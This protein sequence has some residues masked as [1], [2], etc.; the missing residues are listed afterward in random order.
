MLR[1]LKNSLLI[2]NIYYQ[3]IEKVFGGLVPTQSVGTR[4]CVK[5]PST[6]YSVYLSFQLNITKTDEIHFFGN[7]RFYALPE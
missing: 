3:Q 6:D 4:M 5:F 7:P 1:F 2:T